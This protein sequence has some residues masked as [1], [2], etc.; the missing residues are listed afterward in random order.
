MNVNVYRNRAEGSSY[1]FCFNIVDS[2]SNL[3]SVHGF[4]VNE[5][6]ARRIYEK[7]ERWFGKEDEP[8]TGEQAER[9]E[10]RIRG[11][12]VTADRNLFLKLDND[13]DWRQCLNKQWKPGIMYGLWST[14]MSCLPASAF[15]LTLAKFHHEYDEPDDRCAYFLGNGKIITPGPDGFWHIDEETFSWDGILMHASPSDFPLRKAV[16]EEVES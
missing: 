3:S 16:P 14:V 9:E 5:Q 13:G 7:L 12:Y 8:E 1:Y 15:P 11:V 6:E 2:T 4:S 10:P